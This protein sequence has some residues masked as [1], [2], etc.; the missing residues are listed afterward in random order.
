MFP[1][2]E[3]GAMTQP[4][5][6]ILRLL[7]TLLNREDYHQ[8]ITSDDGIWKRNAKMTLT[9]I[10][11]AFCYGLVMGSYHSFLQAISA[12][13]KMCVL[14]V[15]VLIICFPAFYIIQYILGSTLRLTQVLA[16]ILSGFMLSTAIMLSFI[17]IIVFFLLTGSNY[18]FL[19]L[20]HIAVVLLAGV[21]GMLAVVDSLKY[22]CEK[23]GVYPQIGVVVFRFW[24]VILAFVGIQLA[25]N[26]R[27]FLGDRGEGFKLF[28]DYE[29]NFYAAL[30]YSARQLWS[31]KD[32]KQ[33]SA[34]TMQFQSEPSRTPPDLDSLFLEF[35]AEN[36]SDTP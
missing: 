15:L 27:P 24:V 1:E 31:G 13:V 25:W 2:K 36:E 7:P 16:I 4:N 12:G 6:S 33:T 29:G 9:M 20:L 8:R 26:L 23:R 32:Q 17:P 14:E 30:I 34:G 21:F 28:R 5:R 35:S 10:L 18:Y 3:V 22:A 11:F 19:Q